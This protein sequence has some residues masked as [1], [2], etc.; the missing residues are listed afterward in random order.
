[1]KKSSAIPL[2][3]FVASAALI[4]S[5]QVFSS[6]G[7]FISER[8]TAKAPAASSI[9][10]DHKTTLKGKHYLNENKVRSQHINTTNGGHDNGDPGGR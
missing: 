10:K 5:T 4:I 8:H 2:T 1:M 3:L 9:D 6:S 7:N